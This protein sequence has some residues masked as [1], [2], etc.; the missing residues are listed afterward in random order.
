[1]SNPNF[2]IGKREI[3]SNFPPYIIAEMSANHNGS[4]ERA[5]ET[6]LSAKNA[7]VDA[8]KIQ[9]YTPDTI[10]LNCFSDDFKVEG[11]TIWDGEFLYDLYKE[12]Y[13]PWKWH[14]EL[15]DIAKEEDL[16]CFST[17]FDF[18]AVD[19]LEELNCPIYK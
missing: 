9:T 5:K 1:M 14:K 3:S 19:F 15:F 8:I 6:I 10:T 4:I 2:F 18:T 11:G 13:L 12:A 17:P 7:G 16:I